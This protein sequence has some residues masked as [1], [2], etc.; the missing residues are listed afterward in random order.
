MLALPEAGIFGNTHVMMIEK[1]NLEISDLII[2]WLKQ[3]E[4]KQK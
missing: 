1:N 3:V 2:D 4:K